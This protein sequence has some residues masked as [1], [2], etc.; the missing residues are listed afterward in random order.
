[1]PRGEGA[2]YLFLPHDGGAT[3]LFLPSGEGATSLF[4]PRGEGATS[5]FLPHDGCA[6]TSYAPRGRCS[7]SLPMKEVSPLSFCLTGGVLPLSVCSTEEV[8]PLSFL[9]MVVVLPLSFCL[10]EK[11]FPLSVCPRL[12]PRHSRFLSFALFLYNFTSLVRKRLALGPYRRPMPRTLWWLWGCA[13]SYERGTPASV[14]HFE[15]LHVSSCLKRVRP[16]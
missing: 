10:T 15:A 14:L 16:H 13:F 4:L 7:L 12:F 11:R 2:T 6:T 5:L 8:L 3:S 1:M 9:L